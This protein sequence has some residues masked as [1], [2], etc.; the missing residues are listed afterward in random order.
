MYTNIRRKS[1]KTDEY[2]MYYNKYQR[3][4]IVKGP[5]FEI[6]QTSPCETLSSTSIFIK[7]ATNYLQ[8]HCFDQLNVNIHQI[9]I[10]IC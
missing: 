5:C 7:L 6:H 3:K 8:Q 2:Q 4:V 10:K 1:I 9:S